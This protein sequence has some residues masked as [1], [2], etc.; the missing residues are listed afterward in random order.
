MANW[1]TPASSSRSPD[2]FLSESRRKG[3]SHSR[4][5]LSLM[6]ISRC[7]SGFVATSHGDVVSTRLG[8]I[9]PRR[10]H[11]EHGIDTRFSG[12]QAGDQNSP[13][14]PSGGEPAIHHHAGIGIRAFQGFQFARRLH[15]RSRAGN[16]LPRRNRLQCGVFH[17]PHECRPVGQPDNVFHFTGSSPD[18]C[19]SY[20]DYRVIIQGPSR[21]RSSSR[22]DR[23]FNKHP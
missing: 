13:I 10:H 14:H 5:C 15:D 16:L 2:F 1:R 22:Y 12:F 20:S 6:G 9:F 18:S 19:F 11:A 3:F 4:Q 7:G 17:C 21:N 8:P 23:A